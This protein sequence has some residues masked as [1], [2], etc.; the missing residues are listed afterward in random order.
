[1]QE[2]TLKLREG[3]SA[4]HAQHC[5]S[6]ASENLA[7]FTGEIGI[8]FPGLKNIDMPTV[9]VFAELMVCLVC[10]HTQ[11]TVPEDE[12]RLLSRRNTTED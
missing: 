10:G 4:I 5:S 9:F 11:F 12:L 7:R 8:H 1:M 2:F 3:S 6:C